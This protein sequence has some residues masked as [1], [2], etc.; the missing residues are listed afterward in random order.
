MQKQLQIFENE[1]F[2]RLEVLI[3]DDKPYFPATQCAELLGYST[4]RHAVA[5][6]CRGGTKRAV[7][8]QT[9]VKA[10]GTPAFQTIEKT[11]IPEGDLYRLIIRS[12]LPA[13]V[14]FEAWVC[15]EVLPSIRKHGAYVSEDVLR[16]ARRSQAYATDLFDRLQAEKNKT[17]A[18]EATLEDIE[19]G[20]E[21]LTETVATK[22][23]PKVVY[24]DLILQSKNAVPVSV[25]AKDYGM[26]AASFNLLLHDLRIQY[27]LSGTWLLYQAHMGKGYT[28]TRTYYINETTS[29]MHTCWTQ[30][31]RLFLYE[32]LKKHGIMPVL[33]RGHAT[34][35]ESAI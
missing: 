31:G 21:K 29:A 17:A 1:D 32:T 22:L 28:R 13:A 3:I 5:R 30:R 8:V 34:R 11:F 35:R 26:T 24:C 4:P 15:D 9:G 6:H 25:I 12:K 19:I 33:E 7:G 23:M 14:R 20:L 18:L 27:K 16:E 2:G 10:D